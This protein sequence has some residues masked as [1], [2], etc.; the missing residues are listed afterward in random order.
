MNA[1]LAKAESYVGT[2]YLQ[3][4]FDCADL[5]VKVQWEVFNR[6][7]ALPTHRK[8]P[9]GAMGQAREIRTLQGELADRVDVPATGCGVLM[10]EKTDNGP[11][12]HIGTAF[13]ADGET[14]VLHNS[15]RMQSAM[16]Q[17]LGDLQRAGLQ[18]DGYYS[19]RAA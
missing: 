9:G 1:M 5:A 3:G 4:E 11:L 8:R 2:P 6:L 14:W 15:A 18:L 10:F 19:W 16:L 17:R 12:W 7:V 13:L